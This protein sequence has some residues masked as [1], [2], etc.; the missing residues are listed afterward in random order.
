MYCLYF[1]GGTFGAGK[2]T[3]CQTLS[4]LLPGEHLKASELVR[5]TP[6]PKDPTGKATCQVF[7]N[8]ERLIAA[9][10]QRRA[11]PATVLLD[12]H[13]CLLDEIHTI[14]RLPVYVFR[15][16]QPSAFVLVES[17]LREVL[18]QIRR[19]DGREMD[20][21]LIRRLIEA[22]REHSEIV[23]KALGVP[24]MNVNASTPIGDIMGFLRT[25][26]PRR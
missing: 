23:S 2:S 25:S 12:G 21:V 16:I 24:I 1:I 3:L 17:S 26:L 7:G 22:E 18:D 19:R 9:L 15:R 20:P 13:F 5:Y 14:V 8:Q 4:R 11:A 10:A 6:D